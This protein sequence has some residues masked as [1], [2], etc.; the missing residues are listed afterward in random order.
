MGW[1]PPEV[2]ELLGGLGL[3]PLPGSDVDEGELLVDL[4]A[5][6]DEQL[7]TAVRLVG[8]DSALRL[9]QVESTYPFRAERP[10]EVRLAGALLAPHH[11][12]GRTVVGDDGSVGHRYALPVATDEPFPAA[13]L[14]QVVSVL[15]YEA[16][17]F[18][19]YLEALCCGDVALAQ[20]TELVERGEAS[21]GAV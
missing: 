1:G 4:G 8:S 12:L 9:V 10:D 16:I 7:V 15:A 6:P 18:G 20:F 21:D 5:E 13:L 3:A 19:D 14:T 2:A 17:H 11:V